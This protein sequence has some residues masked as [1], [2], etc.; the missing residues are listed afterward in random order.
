M[1]NT[2]KVIDINKVVS[3]LRKQHNGVKSKIIREMWSLGYTRV[4]IKNA[5]NIR[6]QHVRNVLVTVL[7]SK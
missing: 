1:K 3:N 5:L 7:T 2:K 4:E 6:Y